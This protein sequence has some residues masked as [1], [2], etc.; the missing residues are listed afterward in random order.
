MLNPN[1]FKKLNYLFFIFV[2]I[3]VFSCNQQGNNSTYTGLNT[4]IDSIQIWIKEASSK[5]ISSSDKSILTNKAYNRIKKIT[6]DS[7]KSAY[8]TKLSFL[9][10]RSV[11]SLTFRQINKDAMFASLKIKDSLHSAN[12]HWD[13]ASFYRN[14]TKHRDSA[15]YHYSK[16]EKIF[17]ELGD[18]SSS[19]SVLL[20]MAWIQNLTGDYTGSNIT[21]TQAI[22]QIKPLKDY[23]ALSRTYSLMGDNAKLLSEYEES[24]EYYNKAL[25]FLKKD[26]ADQISENSFKNNLGLVYQK[27]GDHKKAIIYFSEVLNQDSLRQKRSRLF[28]RTMNNLAYSYLKTNN[29]KQLPELFIKAIDLQDSISDLAGMSAS[30]YRLA[31]YYIQI[32]DTAKAKNQLHIAKDFATQF[33]NNETLLEVLKSFS[34]VDPK[35]AISYTNEYFQLS[36]SLQLEERRIRNKFALIQFETDEFIAENQLLERQKQLWTGIAAALLLLGLSSFII[37]NQRIKNQKLRFQEEQQIKNQ[38]VF[39][40]MLAQSENVEEGKKLEQKRVSEELHDG[41]LGKMLGARMILLGLNKKMDPES[42]AERAK[43]IG[44]IQ[45]IEGE[46]RSISHELSHAAYQKI[47]NFI[48]SIKDLIETVKGSSKINFEFNYSEELDW[49]ALS[50]D[51][52]INLYR[53]IQESIQNAVKHAACENIELNFNADESVLAITIEDDG[54]GFKIKKGRKGI[55]MRNITSR[56]EKLNGTWDIASELDKGTKVKLLIPLISHTNNKTPPILPQKNNLQEI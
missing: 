40:L 17:T 26:K 16:A 29:L 44:I 13:L 18:N 51:I 12:L 39:N 36:D 49:D 3:F 11:D 2:G 46:V 53:I 27:K 1:I 31:E 35:N 4:P 34:R 42:V 25:Q 5:K 23:S 14:K 21:V 52:K 50:G 24:L 19:G 41:V 56:M 20:Q 37:I 47:H 45:E 38:E 22:K 30:S 33:S 32:K 10:F 9:N 43:A 7:L 8:L 48:L 15:F 6:S 55:G 54:K 28:G